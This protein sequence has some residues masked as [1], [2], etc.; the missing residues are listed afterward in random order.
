MPNFKFDPW[1]RKSP[2]VEMSVDEMVE[3]LTKLYE[4]PV[5]LKVNF[6]HAAWTSE[7]VVTLNGLT[8]LHINVD[9]LESAGNFKG[10]LKRLWKDAY[11]Q[12]FQILL[13]GMDYEER[14]NWLLKKLGAESVSLYVFNG[15]E[16]D[17]ENPLNKE[18][19]ISTYQVGSE[20]NQVTKA[21]IFFQP[22]IW[23]S[24]IGI[25][26]AETNETAMEYLLE[27]LGFCESLREQ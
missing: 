9:Y 6:G 23:E 11:K 13:A 10:E 2:L 24:F 8:T 20:S 5:Q 25:S 15:D 27:S 21:V 17:P 7:T 1:V 4:T 22:R 12:S 18:H 14:Y 3:A 16:S 26:Y 19:V